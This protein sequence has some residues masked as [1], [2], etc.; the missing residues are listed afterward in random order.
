MVTIHGRTTEMRFSGEA[1]LDGIAQV[2]AA[3]KRIPVIGNG[4][5]RRPEDAARMIQRTRCAGVMIGRGALSMPWI[6]RDTWSYLTTGEI[7]PPPTLTEKCD[8]MRRHFANLVQFRDVRVALIEFRKRVSWYAKTMH[9]CRMLRERM[10]LV[11]S[12]NEFEQIIR[13]FLEWRLRYDEDVAAG[14]VVP[15]AE[16]MPQEVM[17]G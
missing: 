8:L 1:R 12:A 17:S 2:V 10:R 3:V 15:T 6:F 13:E 9:P 4:D 7:P 11:Q 5:I 16:A 14:R